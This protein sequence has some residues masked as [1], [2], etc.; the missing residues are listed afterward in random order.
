MRPP[1]T[2]SLIRKRKHQGRPD[3]YRYLRT[4]VE[5]RRRCHSAAWSCLGGGIMDRDHRS[6]PTRLRV[7]C[8]ALIGLELISQLF[9]LSLFPLAGTMVG[10]DL[11]NESDSWK[12]PCCTGG[13]FAF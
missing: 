6:K 10:A 9:A 8:H 5:A 4:W 7:A 2:F 1:R 11:S 12:R 13:S 3:W